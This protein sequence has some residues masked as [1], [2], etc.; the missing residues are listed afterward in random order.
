MSDGVISLW[1]KVPEYGDRI[2][3]CSS[4]KDALCIS[5]NLH[6]PA[7]APQG[8]GY[9][10]SETACAE[11]KRRYKKVFISFDCDKAGLE[12]AQK[13]SEKTGF[14]F[15]VPDLHGEKDYSDYF[16]S[17]SDKQQFKQLEKL[18]H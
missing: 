16:K 14:Q 15:V 6:I 9:D 13:L 5:C 11:L 10:I 2:I 8:E 4:L 17:L 7:I 1:A 18:F 3:I 12:D